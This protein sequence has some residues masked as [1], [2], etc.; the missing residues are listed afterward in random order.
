MWYS[1]SNNSSSSSNNK[2]SSSS[3]NES[4][5]SSLCA[6]STTFKRDWLIGSQSGLI[7]LYPSRRGFEAPLR[8]SVR[9]IWGPQHHQQHSLPSCP[10]PTSHLQHIPPLP[11]QPP[12]HRHPPHQG[13]VCLTSVGCMLSHST[14]A[15][16]RAMRVTMSGRMRSSVYTVSGTCVFGGGGVRCMRE[17]MVWCWQR[18]AHAV[19]R[20]CGVRDLG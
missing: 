4:S 3:N 8:T 6:Y 9:C 13:C 12:P 14:R 15:R 17:A 1:S 5:S 18:A 11:P 20:G 19:R 10:P 2:S 7:P 16:P